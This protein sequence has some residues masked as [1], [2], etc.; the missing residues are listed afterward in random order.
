MA[1]NKFD[2]VMDYIDENIQNDA[3]NIKCGILDLIGINSNSFG[4]YFAVLTNDTLGSYIRSRRLYYAVRALQHDSK[5][6]ICDIALEYGYSDQSAFTRAVTSKYGISPSEFRQKN[7]I[8]F[9]DNN[10]YHF[11]DFRAQAEESRSDYIWREVERTGVLYGPNLD[12]LTS[13]EQGRTEFG[14]SVDTSYAIADLSEKL[15]V[16]VYTLMQACF[17]LVEKIKSAPDYLTNSQFAAMQMGVRSD[18]DL[19]E[20]C[21]YYACNYYELNHIMVREYYQTHNE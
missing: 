9:I 16:P 1:Q 2:L 19:E 3:E 7:T 8:Y 18:E 20:I 13:I 21:E 4:Q 15:E 14:F 10:K 17:D 11:E 6:T 12:F 5:K